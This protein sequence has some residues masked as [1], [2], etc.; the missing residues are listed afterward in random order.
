[1]YVRWKRRR[2]AP[3]RREPG[4]RYA[5]DATLVAAVSVGGKKRQVF[6]AHLGRIREADLDKPWARV[7]FWRG[8]DRGLGVRRAYVAGGQ[9]YIVYPEIRERL[10]AA[11]AAKVPR[12][13]PEEV[14]AEEAA[15]AVLWTKTPPPPRG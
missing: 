9:A 13:T 5:L 2:L 4:E 10:E 3:S 12:P 6:I 14:A 8:I 15:Y 11:L 1:M 7:R